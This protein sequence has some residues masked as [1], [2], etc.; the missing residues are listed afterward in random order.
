MQTEVLI[1]NSK[2][3]SSFGDLC[4][5]VRTMIMATMVMIPTLIVKKQEHWAQH[6]VQFGGF[7]VID[8]R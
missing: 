5:E 4:A 3:N 8:M 7:L 6:T 1:G 2:G